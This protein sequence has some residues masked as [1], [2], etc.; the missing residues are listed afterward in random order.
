VTGLVNRPLGRLVPGGRT[1]VMYQTG[2]NA[3]RIVIDLANVTPELPVALQNQLFGDDLLLLVHSAKATRMD[4][5]GSDDG[6]YLFVTYSRDGT[7]TVDL[8]E[9]GIVRVVVLGSWTNAGPIDGDLRITP[10]AAPVPKWT[11]Q[12]TIVEGQMIEYSFQVPEGLTK[13]DFRLSWREDWSSFPA[14]DLD[15]YLVDPAGFVYPNGALLNSPERVIYHG[16][17]PGTWRVLV[18]GFELHTPDDRYKLRVA[19]DDRVVK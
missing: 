18:H 17:P 12:E 9:P 4:G 7:Y 15:F 19:F 14:T 3:A 13:A 6:D 10:Q 8:P 11:A 2:P 16:P 1:E 5:A